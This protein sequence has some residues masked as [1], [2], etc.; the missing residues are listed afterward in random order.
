MRPPPAASTRTSFGVE[1]LGVAPPAKRRGEYAAN[2]SEPTKEKL[3]ARCTERPSRR[4]PGEHPGHLEAEKHRRE[5]VL[6]C[7]RP[8][9]LSVRTTRDEKKEA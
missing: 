2:A 3:D 8:P 5:P 7:E 1:S 4:G 9:P 6:R